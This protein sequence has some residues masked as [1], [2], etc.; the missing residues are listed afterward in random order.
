MDK[1]LVVEDVFGQAEKDGDS[2]DHVGEEKGW[3]EPPKRGGDR[4]KNNKGKR[5]LRNFRCEK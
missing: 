3:G 4:N 1:G 5:V 2:P